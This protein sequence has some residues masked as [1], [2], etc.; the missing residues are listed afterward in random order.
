VEVYLP[1][2]ATDEIRLIMS[3]LGP[4]KLHLLDRQGI[5]VSEYELT[6]KELSLSS[7]L[8]SSKNENT[9]LLTGTIFIPMSWAVG[10]DPA[11]NPYTVNDAIYSL[12]KCVEWMKHFKG[13]NI[14]IIGQIPGTEFRTSLMSASLEEGCR[15]LDPRTHGQLAQ[16]KMKK[17]VRDRLLSEI[18][19]LNGISADA[20]LDQKTEN[21]MIY[22][23]RENVEKEPSYVEWLKGTLERTKQEEETFFKENPPWFL[24][25]IEKIRDTATYT[26]LCGVMS[27]ANYLDIKPLVYLAGA[28]I[29]LIM[30]NKTIVQ[31]RAEI[32]NRNR[33]VRTTN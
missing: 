14:E 2:S 17:L 33:R 9:G 28:V 30:K 7:T 10:S 23:M 31:L 11:N 21:K 27:C 8:L 12:T 15:R 25:W 4:V 1:T 29:G 19:K 6:L 26:E 18:K 24:T 20:V 13:H 22:D 16:N 3:Y 5:P 32:E